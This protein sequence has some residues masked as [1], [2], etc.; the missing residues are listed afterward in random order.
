MGYRFQR[1]C[2]MNINVIFCLSWIFVCSATIVQSQNTQ[3][4]ELNSCDLFSGSWVHDDTYPL[5]DSSLCPFI[6]DQFDCKKKGR[7]DTDYLKLKWKPTG[8]ELPRF[9]GNDFLKRYKGKKILFVGDSITNN[10]WQ[11]LICLLH[12]AV[13]QSKYT[14]S[15]HKFYLPEYE[16]EVNRLVHQYLVDLVQQSMGNVLQLD[17][18]TKNGEEFKGYDILIFDSWHWWNRNDT[19]KLWDYIQDGTEMVKDMDRLVAYKKALTTWSKWVESNVDPSVT[20]VFFQGL[21]P[22]HFSGETWNDK[23]AGVSCK[24]QTEPINFASYPEGPLPKGVAILDEVL[25]S[26]SKPVTLLNI[27]TLSQF[28]KDG[29]PSIYGQSGEQGNDCLHWCVSGVPDTWNQILYTK[30]VAGGN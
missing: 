7:S 21:A 2:P 16:I 1:H 27:T 18:I 6:G 20:K 15:A 9:D 29:H 14:I 4:S 5:Y 3:E 28:R 17:S 8:C 11:S 12:V 13:P 19:G 26:M 24:G 22:S 10:Q 25:A 30:L 23:N